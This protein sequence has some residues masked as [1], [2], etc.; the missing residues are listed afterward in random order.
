M[1]T[2]IDT[3]EDL[4]FL[5]RE[6]LQKSYIGIDTEFRR[7]SKHNMKLALLQVNDGHEIYLI[8]TVLIS[9]PKEHASFLHSKDVKKILHSCKEDLEAIYS[10]TQNR[11][12]N[13]FDTQIANAFLNGDYSISYQSLVEKKLEILLEK[14][15]T[16]SNWLRRP[17]SDAQLKYAALDVEY[18]IPIYE[19]QN[20]EL[21]R[22]HKLDWLYQDIDQLKRTTFEEISTY[23]QLDRVLPRAQ[24]NQILDSFNKV[25]V[26][27]SSTYE[28]NQ[29]L[30][31]SKKSQKHF[32]RQVL[33]EGI[34]EAC[35]E[36]TNW[37]EYLVKKRILEILK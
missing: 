17:L 35:R 10:W 9:N 3:I 25:V 13:I 32:I 18:L 27:I 16:R 6:L 15:E 12:I 5:N 1:F 22:S 36:I 29:T 11:M 4:G 19:D 23:K 26:E 7:T 33:V 20:K 28:I 8:D 37:R 30:L 14:K 21:S 34:H 2:F 24:E 31:F